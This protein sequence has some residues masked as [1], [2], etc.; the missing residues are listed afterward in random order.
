MQMW[1]ARSR[2]SRSVL[3]VDVC[4]KE[5]LHS[6]VLGAESVHFLLSWEGDPLKGVANHGDV[7]IRLPGESRLSAVGCRLSLRREQDDA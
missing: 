4:V 2:S 3:L 7:P 6:E 5:G 1:R